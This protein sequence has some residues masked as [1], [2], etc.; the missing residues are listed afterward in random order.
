M[1]C[2]MVKFDDAAD[3]SSRRSDIHSSERVMDA[4]RLDGNASVSTRASTCVNTVSPYVPLKLHEGAQRRLH[5]PDL[6]RK[7]PSQK[8][9]V[10][11]LIAV[12]CMA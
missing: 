10:I 7:L 3:P 9:Y 11:T 6:S 2:V 4:H 1:L 12:H 5:T 8:I